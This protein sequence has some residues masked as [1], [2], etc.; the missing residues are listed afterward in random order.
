MPKKSFTLIE[1]LIVILIIAILASLIFVG[2]S[3]YKGKAK[4][5]R[6]EVNMG[7]IQI[8]AEKIHADKGKYDSSQICC[9]S[10]C[11]DEIV[12]NCDEIRKMT[13]NDPEIYTDDADNYCAK[14]KLNNG[15]WYCVDS[16]GLTVED[17]SV[18]CASGSYKCK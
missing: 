2:I 6:A 14:V 1:L 11:N 5:T 7:Q 18:I 4:D 17:S 16:S 13:G 8:S 3:Y 12:T 15:N 9:S 10:E